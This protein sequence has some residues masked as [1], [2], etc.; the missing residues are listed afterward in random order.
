LNVDGEDIR[1]PVSGEVHAY[2]QQQFVRNNPTPQQRQ[3]FATLM[4]VVRAAYKQGVADSR[5]AGA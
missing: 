5:A 2:W 3:R 1:I 4:N